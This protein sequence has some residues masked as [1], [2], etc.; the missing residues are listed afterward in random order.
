MSPVDE[1]GGRH[2]VELPRGRPADPAVLDPEGDR[3]ALRRRH[4][5]GQHP[6]GRA[7]G[8]L[9]GRCRILLTAGRQHHR[10]PRR[11]RQHGH[12]THL[13]PLGSLAG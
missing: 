2:L 6:L 1:R 11:D 12:P 10:Q 9:P 7:H 8:R 4:A 5:V 3:V 13:A